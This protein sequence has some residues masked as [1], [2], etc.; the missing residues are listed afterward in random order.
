MGE[1]LVLRRILWKRY[2]F[3][4]GI[5]AEELLFWGN[6]EQKSSVSV[7]ITNLPCKETNLA[8]F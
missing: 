1:L 3:W 2:S 8:Y 6:S 7:Y 5:F 4:W